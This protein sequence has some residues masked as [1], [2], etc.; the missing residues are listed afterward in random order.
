MRWWKRLLDV[1]AARGPADCRRAVPS[2]SRFLS[3]WFKTWRSR[4]KL[5]SPCVDLWICFCLVFNPHNSLSG[6]T[7]IMPYGTKGENRL[8]S[9]LQVTLSDSKNSKLLGK[10]LCYFWVRKKVFHHYLGC[11]EEKNLI[12]FFL[13]QRWCE[14]SFSTKLPSADEFVCAPR[15]CLSNN[16]KNSNLTNVSRPTGH[17]LAQ[18]ISFCP[19]RSS[20]AKWSLAYSLVLGA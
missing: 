10:C 2:S 11:L 4:S 20:P 3:A 12:G 15:L 19:S 16:N 17:I 5:K 8:T 14:L 7:C 9:S 1:L 6:L 13:G 18:W